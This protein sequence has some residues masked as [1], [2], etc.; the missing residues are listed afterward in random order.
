MQ[1]QIT[2][3]HI[4]ITPAIREITEKKLKHLSAYQDLITHCHI[5]FNVNKTEHK[6]EG[7]LNVRG[8]LIHAE[9]TADELYKAIDE[10]IHKLEKQLS[11]FKEK[12]KSH[13]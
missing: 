1:T 8:N 4:E 7:T 10:M 12:L 9:A 13:R 3:H 11:K 6:A 5:I 2:G